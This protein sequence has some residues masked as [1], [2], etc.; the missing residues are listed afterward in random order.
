[1]GGP[2]IY[3]YVTANNLGFGDSGSTALTTQAG[4]ASLAMINSD[5]AWVAGFTNVQSGMTQNS[6]PISGFDHA[7][8]FG[9]FFFGYNCDAA[10][11]SP[12]LSMHGYMFVNRTDTNSWAQTWSVAVGGI[13]GTELAFGGWV[14]EAFEML[15][16]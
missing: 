1:M 8:Q 2:S 16:K 15:V 11:V 5:V 4:F 6:V 3:P 14:K 10:C 13:G 9:D 12:D 7:G